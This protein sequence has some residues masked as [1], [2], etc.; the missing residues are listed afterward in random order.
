MRN[1]DPLGTTVV[2]LG[3][4]LLEDSKRRL[5]ALSAVAESWLSSAS[6]VLVH[7][8][9]RKLDAQLAARGI[10]R[11]IHEGLRITDGPTLESAVAVLAGIV[12]KSIVS[13]LWG[14]GVPAAG[15][16]GADGATLIAERRAPEG[17]VDFGFVGAG[18]R[19][20]TALLGAILSARMLPVLAPIAAGRKG[21]LLNLNADEAAS[22]TAIA[23]GAR[24]LV[25]L[26]DVQAVDR[27]LHD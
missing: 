15:I 24:R 17:G 13:E 10:P 21:G 14:L 26:T 1:S 5:A 7:G 22:A 3:G 6:L 20:N 4:S 2:K 12:N 9:G 27:E 19:A 25:F 16:S 11:R 23:L 8:G 18:A